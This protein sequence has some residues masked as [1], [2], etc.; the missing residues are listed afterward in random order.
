MRITQASQSP[1]FINFK[2]GEIIYVP[3]IFSTPPPPY[4]LPRR[5]GF[6]TALMHAPIP[7]TSLFFSWLIYL[8]HPP[9]S[10]LLYRAQPYFKVTLKFKTSMKS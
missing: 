4:P 7:S 10:S 9:L 3:T 8:G 2:R 1:L 6:I 5:S